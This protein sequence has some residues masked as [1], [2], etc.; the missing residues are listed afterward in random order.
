MTEQLSTALKSRVL[1]NTQAEYDRAQ[2]T[3]HNE[4][5]VRPIGDSIL[6]LMDSVATTSSGE[7]GATL[8]AEAGMAQ[9]SGGNLTGIGLPIEM[10]NQMNLASESG[11]LV[12]LGAAA[13][14]HYADGRPW[15]DYKP[16]PG[17]RLFVERYAGRQLLGADGRT[18]RM[19][20]YT[21]VAGV[22][23]METITS[24]EKA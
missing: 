12:A 19:M 8:L 15:S 18:Y 21:C 6:V 5:G 17:D 23:D 3:G 14:S 7:A 4:S 9:A 22:E 20:T 2:Y 13:F 1:R 16:G 10:I 11:V 24:N